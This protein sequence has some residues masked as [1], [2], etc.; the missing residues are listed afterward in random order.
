MGAGRHLDFLMIN[1]MVAKNHLEFLNYPKF[2]AVQSIITKFDVFFSVFD[3]QWFRQC[4]ANIKIQHGD[5]PPA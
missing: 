3:L 4:V 1:N 5:L 2:H